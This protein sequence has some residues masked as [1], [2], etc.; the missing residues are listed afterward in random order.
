[1]TSVWT[2]RTSGKSDDSNDQ[3]CRIFRQNVHAKCNALK[4]ILLRFAL[5]L[6]VQ[7]NL[8]WSSDLLL[9]FPVQ[10]TVVLRANRE[11]SKN[12]SVLN[13]S[14]ASTPAQVNWSIHVDMNVSVNC[15]CFFIFV[16]FPLPP[17]PP[18][19]QLCNSHTSTHPWLN[20]M[21]GLNRLKS[22]WNLF[23]CGFDS[24]KRR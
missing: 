8:I 11:K 16:V 14:F 20:Q 3:I 21:I 2:N 15:R 13:N 17:P 10:H 24:R 7:T 5:I 23:C 4:V 6:L 1:M 9:T 18:P 12:P 22:V 19:H